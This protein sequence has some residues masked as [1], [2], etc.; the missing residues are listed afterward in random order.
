MLYIHV[1][2]N[3]DNIILYT[4]VVHYDN[5]AIKGLCFTLF[6]GL[7]TNTTMDVMIHSFALSTSICQSWVV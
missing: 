6:I 3:V 7:M 5:Q 2:N 4:E 1:Y